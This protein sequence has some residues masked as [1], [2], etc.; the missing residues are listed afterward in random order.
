MSRF[1]KELWARIQNSVEIIGFVFIILGVLVLFGQFALAWSGLRTEGDLTGVWLGLL[2]VGLACIAIGLSQ[3]ADKKYTEILSKINTNVVN[4]LDNFERGRDIIEQPIGNIIV[5]PPP[6]AVVAEVVS[7]EVT[8]E[9][10]SKAAAQKRLDE[11]RQRVGYVRG[12]IY[13]LE[14][15]SWGIHWGG[16]YPL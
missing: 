6:V 10:K 13:Q 5:K 14:D 2:S 7:P 11:D 1:L 8:V 12:E 16:K 15:G 9:K 3:K 4:M